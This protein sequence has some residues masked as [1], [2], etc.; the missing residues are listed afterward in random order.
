M[1]GGHPGG[2]AASGRM[3]IIR[4]C[5][6]FISPSD[7]RA[8]CPILS[9]LL[10]GPAVQPDVIDAGSFMSRLPGYWWR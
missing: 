1:T 6:T 7:Q 3:A 9:E 4:P 5:E 8:P 10:H 2:N